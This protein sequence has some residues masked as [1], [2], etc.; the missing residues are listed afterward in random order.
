MASSF[1]D[2]PA[3]PVTVTVIDTT[4]AYELP[5]HFL[6][7]SYET[8]SLLPKD[9]SYFFDPK[10][11]ALIQ[12]LQTLGIKSL[13]IGANAVDDPKILV[14]QEKDLDVF[15]AFARAA[16][17]KV[18]YSFRLKNGNPADSARLASYI[19]AHYSDVLD[20]FSIGNEPDFYFKTFDPYFAVWKPHYDAI[21]QAVPQAM[22][23]G[24]AVEKSQD[25][26]LSM[27]KALSAGGHFAMAS[28]HYYFLRGAGGAEKDPP[29][30]R[31]HFLSDDLHKVYE[32]AYAKTGAVLAA[33]GV[34]YR[35]DELNSCFGG[36]AKD[37]SDTYASTLWALDCTHWWA[38]HH[39][40][41][42]NYHTG[43][44]I[45]HGKTAPSN[46]AAFLDSPDGKGIDMRPQGYAM[47]AFS[48][49]ALGRP[50]TANVQSTTPLDFDAYAYRAKD[51]S[52]YL[53]LINK[54]YGAKAQP[55]SVSLQL[56]AGTDLGSCQRMDLVQKDNDVA[57][58]VGVTLGG[59]SID[60]QGKWSGGWKTV[61]NVNST[62]PLVV[63]APASASIFHISA[64]K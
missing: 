8:S 51:G 24:P 4:G 16:G 29:A 58:K 49:G 46:Y 36:G 55:A 35:L 11:Q 1:G 52:F 47:Q 45:I 14:P 22:F 41:G 57:A 59:G 33:E 60:T 53:T 39:I 9:G 2:V 23:D 44:V 13:R 20:C 64:G 32:K 48:Q 30:A 6:G 7:L 63:I 27:A 17:V 5:D 21:L 10:N 62:S 54:S 3:V 34:P 43:I 28:Y 18:I 61:T 26:V 19:A 38:A 50:V 15:F 31:A 25:F 37:S 12:T 56:P 40:L 42:M